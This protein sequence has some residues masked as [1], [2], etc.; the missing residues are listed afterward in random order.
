M[1]KSRRIDELPLRALVPRTSGIELAVLAGSGR[2][3]E[4]LID[5]NRRWR[6]LADRK[7]RFSKAFERRGKRFHMGDFAGHQELERVLGSCIVGEVDQ[8]FVD[9]FGTGFRSDVA[10]KVDIELAGD[11]QVVG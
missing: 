1:L 10:A 2:V 9:D 8:P 7:P 4:E 5:E 3:V 6:D 11:L